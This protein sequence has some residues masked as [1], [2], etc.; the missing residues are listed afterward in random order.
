MFIGN[1]N[2]KLIDGYE[3]WC[4][5]ILLIPDSI[6]NKTPSSEHRGYN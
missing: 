6:R 3:K 1:I 4:H 5:T 2:V